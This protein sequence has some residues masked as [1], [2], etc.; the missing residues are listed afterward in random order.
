MAR[1]T[2]PAPTLELEREICMSG[3][4][5]VVGM[6]EVGRG[7]LAGPVSVG[8]VAVALTTADAPDG[9]RDSKLLSATARESLIPALTAWA[10][11]YGVGH[12]QPAEI[13][14]LGI[15]GALRLAGRRALAVITASGIEIDAVLLDGSHD[16]LSAP[17]VDL[18][19]GAVA[20]DDDGAW[21]HLRVR[22]Q[23]KADMT[24][25][26]VAA[27]SVLAK[28]ERDSMMIE[29]APQFPS[30]GWDGNKGYGAAGHLAALRAL[31]PTPWHRLSW[32]LPERDPA[33]A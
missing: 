32:R 2:K 23:V 11:G 31:G 13:D 33:A 28:C 18:F 16:W 22:T 30:Y 24:C 19:S 12:A 5:I 14:E 4:K 27:A 21:S 29:L 8:A 9:V 26:S 15:V 17:A 25:A 10:P 3:A 1:S 6:D 7:A 20:G